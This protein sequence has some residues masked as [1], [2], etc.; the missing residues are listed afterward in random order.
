[1][2]PVPVRRLLCTTAMTLLFAPPASAQQ[3][4]FIISAF[5]GYT[6]L[7]A[8]EGDGG[9]ATNA[10]L[11]FPSG[12]TFDRAGN[13][14]IL[15]CGRIRRVDTGGTITTIAG[16][17]EHGEPVG[18]GG[19]AVNARFDA[20]CNTFPSSGIAADDSG[21]LYFADT[22]NDR[23]RKIDARGFITTLA[24]TAAVP[25]ARARASEPAGVAVDGAGNVYYADTGRA[26][27][28]LID[29][30]GTVTKIAGTDDRGCG[31]CPNGDGGPAT[32]AKIGYPTGLARDRHGNL[33]VGDY[34]HDR[35]RKISPDG[36]IS[37]L[38][39]RAHEGYNADGFS[40]DGGPATNA[41][42]NSPDA[43]AVDRAGNV[44]ISD[45][46]RIRRVDPA[47]IITT[48][49]GTPG[50]PHADGVAPLATSVGWVSGLAVDAG[51]AIYLASAYTSR[52]RR[53]GP[54]VTGAQALPLPSA[55][56]CV[57]R[58]AFPIRVR[59]LPGIRF[60]SATVTVNGRRVP[61][62][63]YAER[64]RRIT[65]IGARY[66]NVRRFRAFVDLRG[67][68]KGRY[69]VKITATTT[70]GRTLRSTRR[71]RT[72]AGGLKGGLPP[73]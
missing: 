19:P 37:T 29:P 54:R 52:V 71:Y 13:L 34:V 7:P 50:G 70:D 23:I 24:D 25:D 15:D 16:T 67:L 27:V 2:S 62:Y 68:G 46:M 48:F 59:L 63:V 66:L 38:A 58:R 57:S 39:G 60:T 8:F 43:V 45:N 22:F 21:N 72:C 18:D 31:Y 9:P 47:G 12:L 14:Y 69:A 28:F 55:K 26:G 35:V 64:R 5:A 30:A 73:L 6:P 4:D 44:Y 49:A 40:G 56:R 42:L 41:E 53:I 33:Y 32:A 61:V 10:R 3:N 1:M 51:G 17:G 65:E 36:V 20:S 11:E